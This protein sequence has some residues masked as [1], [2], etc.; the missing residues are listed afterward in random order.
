MFSHLVIHTGI[1]PMNLEITNYISLYLIKMI[2]F[3][4]ELSD[5]FEELVTLP[6]L[7][8]DFLALPE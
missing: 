6:F 4:L 8:A 2:S 1:D 5:E 3:Y 7:E